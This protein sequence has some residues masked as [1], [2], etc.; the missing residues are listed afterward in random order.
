[1]LAHFESRQIIRIFNAGQHQGLPFPKRSLFEG[2]DVRGEEAGLNRCII[3]MPAGLCNTLDP[4]QAI[5][6]A[7]RQ[8]VQHYAIDN[9]EEGRIRAD[10]QRQ[11]DDYDQR[12]SGA[13]AEYP[14]H[15]STENFS[16]IS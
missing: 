12:E 2:A 10:T 16:R 14:G 8:G 9:A 5:H 3:G 4:N 7:N 11:H 13:V 15:Y 6:V 1:M